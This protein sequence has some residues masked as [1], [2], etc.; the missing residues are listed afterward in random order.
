MLKQH[1]Q[2]RA[3]RF[4]VLNQEYTFAANLNPRRLGAIRE[5]WFEAC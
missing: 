1:A 2:A 3:E 4:L 5:E